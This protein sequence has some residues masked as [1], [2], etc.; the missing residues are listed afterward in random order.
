MIDAN[1][2]FGKWAI[3]T[4]GVGDPEEFIATIDK[5]GINI[6]VLSSLKG[7]I[8]NTR[9]GNDEII[10]L[11][12]LYP[13]RFIGL[14]CVNPRLGAERVL[15]EVNRCLDSGLRGI[16][17]YPPAHL[18]DLDDEELMDP[19]MEEFERR[20][21]PVYVTMLL[22]LGIPYGATTFK[23]LRCFVNR[24][25]NVNIV[26][27]GLGYRD[28]L[29]TLRLLQKTDNFYI[30][31]SYD[32]GAEAARWF[33]ERMGADRILM[34]TGYCLFYLS[35]GIAKILTARITPEEKQKIL[36]LNAAKLFS[37]E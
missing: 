3:R 21:L 22:T 23:S 25:R 6:A 1:A 13:K 34:G 8:H 5:H 35:L 9:A 16:R 33:V 30:E 19:L 32:S 27:T 36:Q 37:L 24:Y 14:C 31:L 20:K 11:V 10:R 18:Y 28:R 2:Y 29:D 12:K 15:S 17:L 4:P 7:I 26:A